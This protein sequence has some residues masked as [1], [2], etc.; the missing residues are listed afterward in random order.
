[1]G[2]S[3]CWNTNETHF[4]NFVCESPEN[5]ESLER[6]REPQL[7]TA[8]ADYFLLRDMNIITDI[9]TVAEFW[10]FMSFFTAEI[11]RIQSVTK[12]VYTL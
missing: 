9:C 7:N 5:F 2:F 4:P 1:M 8:V 10:I 3:C 6:Y 11:V 12:N